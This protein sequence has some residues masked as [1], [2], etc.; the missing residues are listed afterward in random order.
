MRFNLAYVLLTSSVVFCSANVDDRY[1]I[2]LVD[3]SDPFAGIG[4][5]ALDI[6]A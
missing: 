5:G 2:A 6:S 1:Y 3:S 4:S